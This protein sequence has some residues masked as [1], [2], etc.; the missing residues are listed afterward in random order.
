MKHNIHIEG[1]AY[2]LR[3]VE[4]QDAEFIVE[5]RTPDR[6]RFMHQIDRTVEAQRRYLEEYYQRPNEYYFVVERRKDRR[7]EGLMSLLDFDDKGHSAQWGRLILRPDSCA[8]AETALLT[9]QLAFDTFDLDEVWGTAVSENTQMIAY[10]ES[11]GFEDQGSVLIHLDGR[12]VDGRKHVLTKDRWK[13]YEKKVSEIARVAADR[14][15]TN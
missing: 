6:T 15:Q 9:L 12:A 3:P 13:M 5:V 14:L 1:F 11:L 2:A 10:V 4:L 7:Q 8:A